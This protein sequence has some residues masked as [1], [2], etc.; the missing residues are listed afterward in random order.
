VLYGTF[1]PEDALLG[2][3]Y[4]RVLEAGGIDVPSHWVIGA[5]DDIV[6]PDYN[7]A[8]MKYFVDPS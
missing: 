3:C 6:L 5:Q 1:S 8:A 2:S 7:R 4:F